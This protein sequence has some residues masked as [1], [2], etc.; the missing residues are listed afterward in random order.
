[1][2]AVWGF[3]ELSHEF[4]FVNQN[5]NWSE[6]Q[7]HC[8]EHYS[9][10]A[11]LT[12]MDDVNSVTWPSSHSGFAWI[13]LHDDPASWKSFMTTDSNSWRWTATGTISPTKF[14]AWLDPY[15]PNNQKSEAHCVKMVPLK[16][17]NSTFSSK[18]RSVFGTLLL[19]AEP[20][21]QTWL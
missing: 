4:Y 21:T 20:L 13:G 10:L 11:T 14:Q 2:C 5:K 18:P 15:A 7:K 16:P 1:M 12:N 17:P 19:I 3:H 8:R 6:A 9:D